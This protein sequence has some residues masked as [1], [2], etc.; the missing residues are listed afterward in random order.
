MSVD[1]PDRLWT[2][3]DVAAFLGVTVRWVTARCRDDPS[4]PAVKLGHY[5]RFVPADIR[6][7]VAHQGDRRRRPTR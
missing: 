3:H 1:S 2:A 6:A 4:F 5:W 7:W